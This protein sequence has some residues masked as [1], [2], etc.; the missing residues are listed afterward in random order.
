MENIEKNLIKI[1]SKIDV[2]KK[3]KEVKIVAVSKK[4]S[5]QEISKAY[6]YGINDFGENYLQ[7]S[8]YKIPKLNSLDITWHFIGHIQSNKCRD[9]AEKFDWVHTIDRVK[10]AR[11]LDKF[12]PENKELR[13]SLIHI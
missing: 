5:W 4:K 3:D 12:C 11:L 7:E 6:D 10:V 8:I 13:L 1:R 2:L 9:I